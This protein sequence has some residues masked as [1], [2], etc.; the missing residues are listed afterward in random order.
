MTATS[1]LPDLE[2]LAAEG[3]DAAALAWPDGD[4][5]ARL[6]AQAGREGRLPPPL[7]DELRAAGFQKLL[8]P[9]RNGGA[10]LDPAP[11]LVLLEE[12]A[13]RSAS[14]AWVAMIAVESPILLSLLGREGFEAVYAN[15]PDVFL[16]SSS[17]AGGKASREDGGWLVSGTWPFVSGSAHC[18]LVM[19]HSQTP[20]RNVIGTFADRSQIEILDDWHSFGL[21]GTSSNSVRLERAFIPDH[22]TFVVGEGGSCLAS[23]AA[24]APISE[25][26]ALHMAAIATG[27]VRHAVDAILA[28]ADKLYPG[29]GKRDLEGPALLKA[30]GVGKVCSRIG[31]AAL[32]DA[33]TDL[34]RDEVSGKSTLAVARYVVELCIEAV[35]SLMALGGSRTVYAGD[36][37]QECLS[38]IYCIA[39]HAN[40]S[41]GR[42]AQLGESLMNS[43]TSAR[44]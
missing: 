6:L 3:K 16:A 21:R 31:R 22:L 19:T 39:Q 20:E 13:S 18:D 10:D 25:H 17:I 41:P 33:M 28:R 9:S 2:R 23:P 34:L 29:S 26:F 32:Q 43:V 7:A 38:D 30:I 36:P 37:I 35:E 40:L 11:V 14:L 44:Q 12:L 27:V 15:G 1:L 4:R 5:L 24:N 42:L 8:L